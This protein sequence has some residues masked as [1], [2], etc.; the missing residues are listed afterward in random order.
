MLNGTDNCVEG[1]PDRLRSR[2]LTMHKD[3]RLPHDIIPADRAAGCP[4]KILLT[5]ATGFLGRYLLREL[6]AS[7]D[8]EIFCLVRAKDDFNAQKRLIKTLAQVGI[9]SDRILNRVRALRGDVTEPFL[10]L[11]PDR[12][13]KFA[14]QVEAIYHCAAEVN[15]VRNYQQLR[16]INVGSTLELLRFACKGPPKIFTFISSL[17]VCF[18]HGASGI[19]DEQSD[20]MPWLEAMPLG[21][22]KTKCVSESLLR[23]AAERGLPV[24]IIRPGLLC[25]D[26]VT[27]TANNGDLISSLI[28][29]CIKQGEAADADWLFD[30][31]PVDYAARAA[32]ALTERRSNNLDTYHLCHGHPRHWRE[33]VLWL[34]L[35]G[36]PV[37][38]VPT[39]AWIK[40]M[41][42]PRN[43]QSGSLF[44]YRSLFCRRSGS[45]KGEYPF[46][47]YLASAQ[48]QI[49]SDSTRHTLVSL[50]LNEPL[51][52]A[53][54]LDRHL[55]HYIAT[56]LF[57]RN[58]RTRIDFPTSDKD[59][60][61][62]HV[63]HP[64]LKFIFQTPHLRLDD[65]EVIPFTPGN[66][67][68]NEIASVRV[69]TGV[70]LKRYRLYYS[71][72]FS[73]STLDLLIKTKPSDT[74]MHELIT[75]AAS[76]CDPELGHH[77]RHHPLALGLEHSHLREPALYQTSHD[78][79]KRHMPFCYDVSTDHSRK[80]WSVAIEYLA[81][82]ELLDS[83]SAPDRWTNTHIEAAIR[84]A[85]SIHSVWYGREND[86]LKQPWLASE[87]TAGKAALMSPL[88]YSLIHYADSFFGPWSDGEMLPL[89]KLF[90]D[91]IEDWWGELSK[92]NRTL[93]HNDYNPR[94]LAF[95]L[96]R[97]ERTVCAFDW[98]L[99]RLGVPQH[100]LA[101]LLCFVFPP[102]SDHVDLLRWIELHRSELE[103]KVGR[104]IDAV[105]W[106][107]GFVISLQQL[108]IDR[109]PFYAIAHRFKPQSFLP[110]VIE[111]WLRLYKMGLRIIQ[112]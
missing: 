47:N 99:A 90:L 5:G 107:R 83:A 49:R 102:K 6:L 74:I 87:I 15:W 77:L 63:F 80:T 78:P 88:W 65:W 12:Y 4:R 18:A 13:E 68:L 109:I 38:L 101:E 56:G 50:G 55:N 25:G 17:A 66:S 112:R 81:N 89:Q 98:E 96:N 26:T 32:I 97:G 16:R 70:G 7:P 60:L 72:E 84:G 73:K 23:A 71:Q 19:I 41:F 43:D 54:L 104:K 59:R 48:K 91:T 1:K 8:K 105:T 22:A 86:L 67:I 79:M 76:L 103:S 53:D 45:I 85:A 30:V 20:M 28:S 110:I 44:G 75:G 94:N 69:G 92:M 93:I 42:D 37:R 61:P 46:E 108:A 106:L 29:A 62:P 24:T 3:S 34:N 82:A 9:P 2:A 58:H 27:G 33:M 95:R 57:P 100:D 36:Y 39:A 21:Y 10:G 111:N 64:S 40:K 51:L 52:D 11:P 31:I 35:L 14:Q